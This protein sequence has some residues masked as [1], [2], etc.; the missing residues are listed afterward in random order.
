M[1]IPYLGIL[2]LGLVSVLTSTGG[3][4]PNLLRAWANSAAFLFLRP[5][6]LV[7][8]LELLLLLA[9]DLDLLELLLLLRLEDRAPFGGIMPNATLIL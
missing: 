4:N 8:F 5:P 2:L 9:E 7:T 6:V 3:N 1:H